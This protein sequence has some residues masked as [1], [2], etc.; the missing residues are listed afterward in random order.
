MEQKN[1]DN[2]FWTWLAE[3]V[4]THPRLTKRLARLKTEEIVLNKPYF[5]PKPA[6]PTKVAQSENADRSTDEVKMEDYSKYLPK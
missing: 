2:G 5:A 6:T 1:T 4:S 3:K